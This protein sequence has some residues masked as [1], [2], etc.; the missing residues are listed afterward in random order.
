MQSK[1][2][3]RRALAMCHSIACHAAGDSPGFTGIPEKVRPRSGSS[4]AWAMLA[5]LVFPDAASS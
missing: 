5:R 3:P 2:T 4:L 1:C